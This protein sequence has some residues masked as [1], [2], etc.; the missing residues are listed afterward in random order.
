MALDHPQDFSS[1]DTEAL[2][3]IQVRLFPSRCAISSN[4]LSLFFIIKIN[5]RH[6][7]IPAQFID[8]N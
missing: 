1:K 4:A 7:R 5:T 8:S 3:R 6:F 2:R